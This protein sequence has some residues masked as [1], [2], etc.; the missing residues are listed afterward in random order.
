[1][2]FSL[3]TINGTGS[4]MTG[5]STGN[6]QNGHHSAAEHQPT[7]GSFDANLYSRML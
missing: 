6:A 2:C 5:N 7:D 4:T 1:M 3:Q